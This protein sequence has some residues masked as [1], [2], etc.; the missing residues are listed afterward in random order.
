M[1]GAGFAASCALRAGAQPASAPIRL[2][3]LTGESFAEGLYAQD[4]GFFKRAGL[5]VELSFLGAGGAV[6]AAVIGGAA[7]VGVTNAGSM[8]AAHA[9]GLPLYLIA[10]C[11]ITSPGPRASTVLAV[12]KGSNLRTAGDFAG[13][14]I[15]VSTVR[16]LQQA[17]TMNWLDANGGD[18][19]AATFLEIPLANQPEALQTGRV[20]AAVLIEPWITMSQDRIRIVARPYD[21]IASRILISG[22]I[23]NKAWFDANGALARRFV[24]ALR[25]TAVWA[26]GDR[27]A[28][29]AILEKYTKIPHDVIAAMSR[30][31]IGERLDPRLI[32]PVIDVS[33]RYGFLPNAFP[34]SALF[35]PNLG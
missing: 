20:D 12:A 9:R 16:D 35:A 24:A 11:T 31:T 3:T 5:D 26:N 28:T 1:L 4:G 32:Q 6:T 18:A 21:S 15:C 7:D 22:W 25:A 27:P 8:S 34:A 23:A 14:T 33:A 17:A 19:K 13:K 29:G 10:P 2:A 30:L